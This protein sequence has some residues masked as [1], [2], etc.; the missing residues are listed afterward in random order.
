MKRRLLVLAGMVLIFGAIRTP[1]EWQMEKEHQDAQFRTARLDLSLREQIGQ[2]GFIAALSGFRSVVADLLWI[3]AYTA[4]TRTEYGRMALIFENVV[5]LQPRN[6]YFWDNAAWHMAWNGSVYAFENPR[7]PR[8]AIRKNERD[9]FY[10]LGESFLKRGI[11]NNPDRYE[12]NQTYALFLEQKRNDPCGA[13][14]QYRLGSLKP[15]APAFMR[16]QAAIQLSRCPGH[17]REAYLRLRAL[18]QEGE[19][20]RK[21]T[22]VRLV[23]EL[24]IQL[25][26]PQEERVYNPPR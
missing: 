19:R 14:E 9:Q 15:D 8:Q 17:E 23:R 3:D 16:R 12:L 18:W 26:I 7:Q 11:Q 22:L 2:S 10:A 24:E 5:T 20:E 1:L 6:Y 25:Q 21:P 4:W 13:A